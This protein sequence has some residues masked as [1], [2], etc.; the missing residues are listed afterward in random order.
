MSNTVKTIANVMQD[1]AK[2]KTTPYDSTATVKRVEGNTAWVHIPGGVDETPVRMTIAAKPGDSVQVRVSGGTAFLVGNGSAPPT[3]D[4]TAN[5]AIYIAGTAKDEASTAHTAAVEA[6]SSA[7]E[8]KEAATSAKTSANEAKRSADEANTQATYATNYANNALTQLST[9][10]SVVDALTWISEHSVFIPT[11]DTTVQTSKL[12]YLPANNVL[13]LTSG[14]TVQDGVTF[15]V[16]AEA[17]EVT[18]SGT[19]TA[20][21]VFPLGIPDVEDGTTI[22]FSGVSGG[23]ASTYGLRY[24]NGPA[25]VTIYDGTWMATANS[26]S[27]ILANKSLNIYV[28]NGAVLDSVVFTPKVA[29]G[30]AGFDFEIVQ[31]P[32]GNPSAQGWYELSTDEAVKTYVKSHLALTNDGL[33]VLNDSSS[34]KMLLANDGMYIEAPN[35]QIVNQSTADGNIIK[36]TNGDVI[37]HLGY[38]RGASSTSFVDAPYYT[39][40]TRRTVYAYSATAVYAVGDL[41]Y[42]DVD[43]PVA[44]R[45]L[46]QC[47]TAIPSGEEFNIN[48]WKGL[49]SIF[50]NYS[51]VEGK[52]NISGGY[53]THTEGEDNINQGSRTHVEG[54]HNEILFGSDSHFEGAYHK[55][56]DGSSRNHVQGYGHTIQNGAETVT[57]DSFVSGVG[58]RTSGVRANTVIGRYATSMSGADDTN[59]WGNH[60]FKI[61]NG[62]STSARSDALTVDWYGNVD[63]ASG[64]HYKINGTNLSAS[65]V[66]ALPK[67]SA[68]GVSEMGQYIDLHASGGATDY[69]VR[70][71][72]N[73]A[74]STGEGFLHINNQ[75]MKDFVIAHETKTTTG[76]ATSWTV[77]RWNSGYCEAY[78]KTNSTGYPMTNAYTNGFYYAVTQA[79]PSS[80][81]TSVNYGQV[82]RCGGTSTGGLITA[83]LYNLSTTQVQWYAFDTRS[84]TVNCSFSI[85]IVGKWK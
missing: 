3:D 1:A 4:A 77:R 75:P 55:V 50:G 9:V 85:R 63:I 2:D 61:G 30:S 48:H 71:S 15:V 12:Y 37:A 27:T 24:R 29:C 40:G 62:T 70:L 67:P 44:H 35:A 43:S 45:A 74:T 26:T 47:K 84:E 28:G 13:T 34:Y 8:A 6:V 17:G 18:A 20:N 53:S 41:C 65:D 39:F 46:Y 59:V 76:L 21:I 7:I 11:E 25:S 69:D 83:S 36:A 73:Q 51:V 82:D 57:T 16:D 33:Y 14:T 80:L 56:V 68:G 49:G 22:Y 32:T 81:F 31:N 54:Q 42:R 5:T 60:A 19:A 78:T 10:E 38:G 72:T 79:L 64:A 52:N 58:H 66:G 23:S